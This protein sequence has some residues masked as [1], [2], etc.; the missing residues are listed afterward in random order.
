MDRIHDA[1]NRLR[2]LLQHEERLRSQHYQ[3]EWHLGNMKYQSSRRPKIT[4]SVLHSISK[5]SSAAKTT[6]D[7]SNDSKQA[8]TFQNQH[9]AI[10]PQ[11]NIATSRQKR[12]SYRLASKKQEMK[13]WLR[14]TLVSWR[15]LKQGLPRNQDVDI[16]TSGSVADEMDVRQVIKYRRISRINRRESF[17]KEAYQWLDTQSTN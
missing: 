12:N 7:M 10:R 16:L 17:F 2:E 13:R 11:V 3:R 4:Q 9:H 15:K 14:D 1:K 5:I 8:S 6:N